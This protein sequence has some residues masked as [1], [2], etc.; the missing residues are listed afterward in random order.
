LLEETAH[1][2]AFLDRR[3]VVYPMDIAD[4]INHAVNF[5]GKKYTHIKYKLSYATQKKK[6][7][8]SHYYDEIDKRLSD[9]MRG[10][11]R[12]LNFYVVN[13]D[14]EYVYQNRHFGKIVGK[15]NN[16]DIDPKSW[17]VSKR[18]M[19]S[20]ISEVL[21]EEFQDTIYT[22]F[23]SPLIISGKV[24]GVIGL[25]VD[26][27]DKK[28]AEKLE[29]E[30]KM[31]EELYNVAR[32]VAHDIA[33]PVTVLKGYLDLN[34]SL[35]KEEKGIF[36]SCARNI[37]NI[38]DRLLIKYRG[39]KDVVESDY[40]VVLWC[41]E[42]VINQK[43]EQ[44]KQR[45]IEIKSSS[46]NMLDKFEFI[47]GNFIDFSRML[48]NLLNNAEEAIEDKEG[49]IEVSC[50][51]MEEEVEIRVKD[52]GKGMP[53]EMAERI[54]RG[55]K[56]CTTKKER[57]GIGTQQINSAIREMKGKLKIESKENEG[58]EIILTFPRSKSPKWFVDKIEIKKGGTLV[59][60]DD[61][62]L[63]HKH[64][65][66]K[67]KMYENEIRV[68][69]FSQGLEALKYLKSLEERE[70]EKT[71]LISDYELREQE[72]N[73][74]NVID[75]SGMKDRHLLVTNM[76]LSNIKELNKKSAYI[77]IFHKTMLNDISLRVD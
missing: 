9:F 77:K 68:E 38:S 60:L 52:N 55:E 59:I 72:M 75:K 36:E 26:I 27:T 45:G 54:E 41:L 70:K 43:R 66:E 42:H 40:V 64:W 6:R 67:L 35:S 50:E 58:T 14:G 69:Y 53:Q 46:F 63:I 74:V 3:V 37:E 57:H 22:S 12:G 39:G 71:F 73:G 23:K 20:E 19:N 48:L 47:K 10:D 25:S 61:E 15:N 76:Y 16:K 32:Y 21:E 62:E 33:Q 65:Q 30:L 29:N 5:Y 34:K 51:V 31:Q 44:Y 2:L 13:R 17:E 28:K 56:V 49:K 4:S 1:A 7:Y 18:V 11:I 8:D 24:E